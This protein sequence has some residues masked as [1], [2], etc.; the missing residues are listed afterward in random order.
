MAV[1]GVGLDVCPIERMSA[2][3][4]RHGDRFVQRIF[5]PA[6]IA[7]ASARRNR[8][9]AYAARFAAKEACSKALGAPKGIDWHDV[10]VTPA[11]SG[12]HGPAVVLRGR[13][14]EV[15][16]QRG[17]VQIMLSITHAAGVA[18]AVAIAVD[19]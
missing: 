3:I 18:A 16:E 15:A 4:A 1:L 13:A 14:R 17:V 7:Y 2:A 19:A 9:E 6:E 11:R 8:D 12:E 5:T 10:E